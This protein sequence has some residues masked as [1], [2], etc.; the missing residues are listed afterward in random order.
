MTSKKYSPNDFKKAAA[1]SKSVAHQA[2]VMEIVNVDF[3]D[4][5][6]QIKDFDGFGLS[7]IVMAEVKTVDDF[8]MLVSKCAYRLRSILQRIEK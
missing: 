6:N 1:N 2:Q 8:Q 7:P 5:I 3:A 4:M